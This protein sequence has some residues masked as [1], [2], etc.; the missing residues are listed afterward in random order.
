MIHTYT[1]IYKVYDECFGLELSARH[2]RSA[3]RH[4]NKVTVQSVKVFLH[5]R[6]K[7]T[8][9][10]SMRKILRSLAARAVSSCCSND[11]PL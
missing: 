11:L 8:I 5:V 1:S 3:L 7:C 6:R 4:S 9:V 2:S 10:P